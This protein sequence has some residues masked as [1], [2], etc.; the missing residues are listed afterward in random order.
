MCGVN[1]TTQAV[2]AT[3][4]VQGNGRTARLAKA[5][6][7]SRHVSNAR[8]SSTKDSDKDGPNDDVVIMNIVSDNDDDQDDDDHADTLQAT[9]ST[10]TC[11]GGSQLSPP[12]AVVCSQSGSEDDLPVPPDLPAAANLYGKAT[13]MCHLSF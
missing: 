8:S 1:K 13:G 4:S 10:D 2:R 5:R 6:R 11:V 3:S 7:R 9:G 12:R